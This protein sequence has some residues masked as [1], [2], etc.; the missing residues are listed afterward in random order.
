[1]HVIDTTIQG[2]LF[3]KGEKIKLTDTKINAHT[4]TRTLLQRHYEI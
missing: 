3:W 4:Y 2:C 1:M